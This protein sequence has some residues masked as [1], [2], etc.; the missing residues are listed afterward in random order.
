MVMMLRPHSVGATS[1]HLTRRA[2]ALLQAVGS[3]TAGTLLEVPDA[4]LTWSH[5]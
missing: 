1:Q 4:W 5:G 2:T 3:A